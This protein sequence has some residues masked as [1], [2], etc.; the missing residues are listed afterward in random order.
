MFGRSGVV[1]LILESADANE[2]LP[3]EKIHDQKTHYSL[4]Y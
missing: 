4:D 2:T 3:P 1:K